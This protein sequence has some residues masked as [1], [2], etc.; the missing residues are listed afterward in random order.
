MADNLPSV[1]N[2]RDY[3]HASV[4]KVTGSVGVAPNRPVSITG[5][6]QIQQVVVKANEFAGI[7]ADSGAEGDFRTVYRRCQYKSYITGAVE[8]GQPLVATGTSTAA[9][10]KAAAAVNAISGSTYSAFANGVFRIAGY[11]AQAGADG[12]LI[13]IDL[14]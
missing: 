4:F 13:L 11:A 10:F 5:S 3:G 1:L 12:D 2:V 14:L 7:V 6:L 9:A 8:A